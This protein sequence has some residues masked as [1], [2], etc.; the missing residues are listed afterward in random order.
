MSGNSSVA[1]FFR[2]SA[3]DFKKIP[4]SPVAY[5][6]SDQ[7]RRIFDSGKVLK[8]IGDTRQGMATSD[9]NRFLRFWT[10]VSYKRS[11]L[12]AKTREDAA[13]SSKKWFP[14]NKGGDF[15]K[16]YGNSE[17]VVNWENNGKELLN[18]AAS[19]YGSPT[20]TIKSIS[21][22]FK[23][24]VSWSKISSANIAMRFYPEGY[25]FD[26]A[27]CCI[28]STKQTDLM[29]LLGYSNTIMVRKLLSSIS[30][31]LNF[32]AGH[33][34]SLPILELNRAEFANIPIKLLN[35]AK[36][37]WDSY[38]TSWDFTD[39]PLLRQEYRKSNLEET[40]KTLRSHWQDMTLE[41][42]RLE[43]KNNCIFIEA[44]GLQD[45]LTPEVPLEEITL[46][47]N[48]HYRYGGRKSDAELEALLLAD[49]M[50]EYISY[51][52]GCIFGRY[53]LDK[54]GLVLANA[55]EG[56]DE[57]LEQVP[58][59]SFMPDRDGILPVTEE[60]DFPDDL[61]GRFRDFL[62]L[63][64]GEKHFL[65]NLRFVEEAL[66]KDI[67]S[68]FLRDFYKDHVRRYK[69]RPIYWMIS[70]PKGSFRCLIY[71]HRYTRNTVGLFLDN[72]LRPYQRKLEAKEQNLEHTIV[73]PSAGTA[74]KARTR[75]LQEKL[76]G[77][78]NELELWQRDV[79]YP[80]ATQRIDL[81][82]DDGVRVN[83]GKLGLVLEKV[84][85]LNG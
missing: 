29:F 24:C 42:Q 25:L 79:V 16:W 6:V 68:Y 65:T 67:R 49:T 83:Y 60:D 15:R 12:D 46:T 33:I 54:P 31:T 4:G 61:A 69:N 48:P 13:E 35:R 85:G 58:N 52:V 44:Y 1:N 27:G 41:M 30:P 57:Y 39:L 75:K 63:T 36:S 84:K 56:I 74:E 21:E 81:D 77:V 17:F 71:L 18:Y 11:C 82:L 9:N 50:R 22:Y 10:E 20:R 78:K 23:P 19:L 14:Y 45:E 80:L 37:D 70:S 73:S 76:R 66:G 32:E 47:C 62:K 34:A 40:Y 38:E 26:V 28:F 55:G 59:P 64:F 8:E 51:A 3:E 2:A 5:W 43:E 72:Y 7:M 53:S